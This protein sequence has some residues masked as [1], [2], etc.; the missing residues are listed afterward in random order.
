MTMLQLRAT[1]RELRVKSQP[2][3]VMLLEDCGPRFSLR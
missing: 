3:A 1:E 2:D